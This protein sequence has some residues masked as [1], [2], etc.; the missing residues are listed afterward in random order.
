M[1]A[2]LAVRAVV[3]LVT[4]LI[5]AVAQ[6]VLRPALRS[7]A[8]HPPAPEGPVAVRAAGW[9]Q[10]YQA[11]GLFYLP[12]LLESVVLQTICLLTTLTKDCVAAGA[13]AVLTLL[14]EQ[15]AR[16]VLVAAAVAYHLAALVDLV[17]AAADR[18]MNR[19]VA[20]GLAAAGEVQVLPAVPAETAAVVAAV[21]RL[22][23]AEK[24]QCLCSGLR[25]TKNEI[26]MD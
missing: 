21:V 14:A 2:E 26:R 17:E 1:A 13:A 19:R 8:P 18:I 16:L 23:L 24:V 5:V 9:A 10:Q 12:P 11:A 25:G 3:Q 15:E 22:A 4:R 6:A 20:A 7:L